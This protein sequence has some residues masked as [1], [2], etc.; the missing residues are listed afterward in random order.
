M[1]QPTLEGRSP[2][3]PS[4]STAPPAAGSQSAGS[5]ASGV[6]SN[7]VAGRPLEEQ[8]QMLSPNGRC[9]PRDSQVQRKAVQREGDPGLVLAG[10][11]KITDWSLAIVE[12]NH[13]FRGGGGESIPHKRSRGIEQWRD[14][15]TP[16]D[17]TPVWQNLLVGAITI[18]VGAATA[19]VGSVILAGAATAAQM[20]ASRIARGVI[21]AAVDAGKTAVK[22]LASTAVSDATANYSTNGKLAY[23]E[24][25]KNT[26]DGEVE[27]EWSAARTAL[28]SAAS[29]PAEDK[30]AAIQGVYNGVRAAVGAAQGIQFGET[31]EGW[32]RM[33][34][35]QTVGREYSIAGRSLTALYEGGQL[36]L[37][38]KQQVESYLVLGRKLTDMPGDLQAAIRA[39]FNNR[40]IAELEQDNSVTTAT[41]AL[42]DTFSTSS[43]GTLGLHLD[44]GAPTQDPTVAYAEI[45][46]S[47]GVNDDTR[48]YFL[49]SPKKVKDF[50]VPKILVSSDFSMG[51]NENGEMAEDRRL[52]SAPGRWL[53]QY[54]AAKMGQPLTAEN[55]TTMR[56]AARAF[57]SHAILE[58]SL[59]QLGVTSISN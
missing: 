24:A 19:G 4:T 35:Q 51:V 58:K 45:E 50:K 44:L 31:L 53:P 38:Q 18:A 34:A 9:S 8:I 57:I 23:F 40:P 10:G 54:G 29:Q 3:T 46:S 7:I 47:T 11:E 28:N 43:V 39:A 21:N 52:V 12:L 5:P 16:N 37:Q 32:M 20:A 15:S 36:T 41:A 55:E 56:V 49:R 25:T 17:P 59:R 13:L 30:W 42:A 2:S 22:N 33:S 48:N 14:Q 1:S 27:V 26:V 6:R